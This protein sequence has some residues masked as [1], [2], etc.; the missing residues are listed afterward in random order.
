MAAYTGNSSE[1]LQGPGRVEEGRGPPGKGVTPCACRKVCR[2]GRACSYLLSLLGIPELCRI[3]G[4]LA[5]LR[6]ARP[7]AGS[8][9]RQRHPC[10]VP[11]AEP[12]TAALGAR[13]Q[14][15]TGKG[16][17]IDT[18]RCHRTGLQVTQSGRF[19]HSNRA[20]ATDRRRA[21]A[22]L[23]RTRPRSPI[24]IVHVKADS[25]YVGVAL[26]IDKLRACAL[27]CVRPTLSIE[28]P[29]TGHMRSVVPQGLS[30]PYAR[31][32]NRAGRHASTS[33][34]LENPHEIP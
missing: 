30:P 32:A 7:G 18:P 3:A 22:G 4:W 16:F 12:C 31:V 28:A 20:A 15:F 14:D 6:A 2:F 8:R 5:S 34:S 23:R 13:E 17:G 21:V 19:P 25:D 1:G 11:C 27:F 26:A 24:L 10:R 33:R 29:H 9:G